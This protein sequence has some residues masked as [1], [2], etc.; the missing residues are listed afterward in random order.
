MALLF[1]KRKIKIAMKNFLYIIVLLILVFQILGCDAYMESQGYTNK[2]KFTDLMNT[3]I[4]WT[5]AELYQKLGPANEITDDGQGG[6]ILIY[7]STIV[8]QSAGT[9][10]QLYGQTY[11]TAPQNTSYDREVMFFINSSGTIYSWQA[12]GYNFY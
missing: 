4:G 9:V 12:K 10:Y 8:Q 1:N 3:S 6:S 5:K 11:Y 2:Q 7:T